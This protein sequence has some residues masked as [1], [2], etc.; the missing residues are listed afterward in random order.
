MVYNCHFGCCGPGEAVSP[1]TA[2]ASPQ[3]E[4][5]MNYD[6]ALDAALQRLHVEGR[7]RTFIDLERKRG[8][9]PRATWR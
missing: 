9:F 3:T 2:Q 7:Y 6:N 5:K 4:T 1:A 8:A